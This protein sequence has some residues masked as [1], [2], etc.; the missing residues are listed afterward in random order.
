MNHPANWPGIRTQL[1]TCHGEV[2]PRTEAGDIE[3]L[4]LSVEHFV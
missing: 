3:Q 1:D 4:P 2:I